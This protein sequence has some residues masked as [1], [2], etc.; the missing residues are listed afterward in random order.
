L[1]FE[2]PSLSKTAFANSSC[3]RGSS[4]VTRTCNCP[5]GSRSQARGVLKSLSDYLMVAALLGLCPVSH[6]D[7]PTFDRSPFGGS[8]NVRVSLPRERNFI[9]AFRLGRLGHEDSRSYQAHFLVQTLSWGIKE[10]PTLRFRREHCVS[11][12]LE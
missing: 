9:K 5:A 6:R 3:N 11:P 12:A 4:S 7:G 1:I 8:R 2:G 10:P